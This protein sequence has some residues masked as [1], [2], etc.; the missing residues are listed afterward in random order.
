MAGPNIIKLITER[1]CPWYHF[2][3]PRSG[4]VGGLI[5]GAIGLILVLACL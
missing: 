2:W 4:C 3:D 1:G 5:L